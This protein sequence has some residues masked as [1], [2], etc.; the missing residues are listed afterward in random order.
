MKGFIIFLITLFSTTFGNCVFSADHSP[1]TDPVLADVGAGFQ[2]QTYSCGL[3]ADRGPQSDS[4]IKQHC[5]T[6]LTPEEIAYGKT[7]ASD[8]REKRFICKPTNVG[9]AGASIGL[10][11]GSLEVRDGDRICLTNG[12]WGL[13]LRDAF[14]MG[15]VTSVDEESLLLVKNWKKVCR[16]HSVED[17]PAF[18]QT[19]QL[20]DISLMHKFN[21]DQIR[22][23]I[24]K[25]SNAAKG[26]Q[27][28][29]AFL[30]DMNGAALYISQYCTYAPEEAKQ[31]AGYIEDAFRDA[32]IN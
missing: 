10:E 9:K 23:V 22:Q 11:A 8:I 2:E 12:Q 13:L 16:T 32:G 24:V 19:M 1:V 6:N 29:E 17:L 26:N 14:G 21:R 4:T 3:Y 20:I 31:M 15:L 5:I 28:G 18:D 30:S 25:T 7:I 27:P